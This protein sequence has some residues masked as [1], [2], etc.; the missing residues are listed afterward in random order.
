MVI[1]SS[2]QL[3]VRVSPDNVIDFAAFFFCASPFA[4]STLL[5]HPSLLSS[6]PSPVQLFPAFSSSLAQLL[7]FVSPFLPEL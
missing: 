5:H 6:F 7:F 1:A 2:H 4:L 3:V